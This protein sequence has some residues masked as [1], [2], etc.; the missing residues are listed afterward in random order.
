[1]ALRVLVLSNCTGT[2]LRINIEDDLYPLR[3][4]RGHTF[5]TAFA[6]GGHTPTE[7]S[8][9]PLALAAERVDKQF[10]CDEAPDNSEE[11]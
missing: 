11:P 9:T 5:A 8:T 2:D 7:I 4:N 6:M 1:M 3:P 10:I